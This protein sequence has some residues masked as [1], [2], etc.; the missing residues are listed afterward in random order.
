[1]HKIITIWTGEGKNRQGRKRTPMPYT[2]TEVHFSRSIS[3]IKAL[4]QK[5]N[6]DTVIEYQSKG[7]AAAR[8]RGEGDLYTLGFEKD[9]L[10]YLVEFP[11][12]Y[13]ENSRGK[14]LNMDISGRI[15]YNRIKAQLIDVEIGYLS[16]HE[17]MI[18][19]LALPTPRGVMTVMDI[20]QEQ[21]KEIREGTAGMFLLTSG[22]R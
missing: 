15:I 8:A 21:A 4:L 5:F 6:C 17:A 12:T 11:I 10:K 7:D 18:S 22:G 1:M 3:E 14:T 16:F 13:V 2:G 19:N 20:V 9:G